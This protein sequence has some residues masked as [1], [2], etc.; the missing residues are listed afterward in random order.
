MTKKAKPK[1]RED[2]EK[3]P[4][5]STLA[6]MQ[7][8]QVLKYGPGSV[9]KGA[10][11]IKC[12]RI[13][14]G[15]LAVDYATGGGLPIYGSTCLWGPKSGG[16]TN[17]A[18][19]AMESTI[20]FC[21]RC[22][23]YKDLCSCSRQSIS[24]SPMFVDVEGVLDKVWA[25][26]VGPD[27]KS[28]YVCLGDYGEMQTNMAIEALKST[29][30]GLVVFDS[31]GQLVPAAEFD[32]PLDDKFYAIQ[33]RLIS[34]FVRKA[35]Q[36]LI[37]E[38]KH[39]HPVAMLFVNQKRASIGGGKYAPTEKMPGGNAMEHEFSLLL[40]CIQVAMSVDK[41]AKYIDKIKKLNSAAKFS[42]QIQKF[43]VS[44]VSGVAEYIRLIENRPDLGLK[45]GQ[46][47]DAQTVLKYAK[48]HGIIQDKGSGKGWKYFDKNAR[49]LKDIGNVWEK[50]PEEYLRTKVEI[51]KRAKDALEE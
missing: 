39:G 17:L 4:P 33:A 13:P 42:I 38:R 32:A 2:K 45:K 15:V 3:A 50:K 51:I 28:Y 22:F 41:D 14:F 5:E 25:S 20:C 16:K 44:V 10:Q 26:N 48:E 9:F 49:V 18:I 27:P 23:T 12:E 1:K 30:C 7:H 34:R 29:D 40:R 47:D 11:L 31:L 43:K 35:K 6:F 46:V 8:T 36:R 24:L 21:F 19:S 37:R